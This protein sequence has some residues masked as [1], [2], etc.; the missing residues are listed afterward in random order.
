MGLWL[1][2][3]LA[4]TGPSTSAEPT[5]QLRAVTYNTGTTE[6]LP[7]DTEP[8][9]G[10]TSD[11]AVISDTYFGDGLAWLPAV[12]A[13]ERFFAE[14]QPD[15]VAFQE[16][17]DPAACPDIPDDVATGFLC[18]TWQPGDPTVAEQVMGAGYEVVCHT[19]KSDKCLAVHSRLGTVLDVQGADVDGCGTGAR[20]ARFT[21]QD[22]VVISV[23]GSSGLAPEDQDCRIAQ[24]DAALAFA[25]GDVNLLLGDLNT[26]PG[27]WTDLDD[28]AAHWASLIHETSALTWLTDIGPDAVPTYQGI[29]NID[30]VASDALEGSCFTQGV[31]SAPVYEGVYFDHKPVV[32]DL[33]LP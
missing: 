4:C 29:V 13:V 1:V 9:D 10:Y 30:H 22:L 11:H 33:E 18:E 17:F 20:V 3:V 27:R 2:T 23:H 32:C 12:G 25:D 16:I 19:G 15:L 26:D 7:H 14:T 21:L 31:D 6:G 8:D 24:I 5:L 28:S